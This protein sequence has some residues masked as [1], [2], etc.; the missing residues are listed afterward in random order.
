MHVTNRV[1]FGHLIN[2]ESFDVT[3]TNPDLYQIMDNKWDWEQR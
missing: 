2:P 1:D 3:R